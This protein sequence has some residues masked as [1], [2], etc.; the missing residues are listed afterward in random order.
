MAGSGSSIRVGRGWH[1][2]TEFQMLTWLFGEQDSDLSKVNSFPGLVTLKSKV[3]WV[4]AVNA[5]KSMKNPIMN[6]INTS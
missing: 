6:S 3:D 1:R 5:D 4:F 2:I